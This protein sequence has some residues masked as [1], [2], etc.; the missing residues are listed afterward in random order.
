MSFKEE[1]K[2]LAIALTTITIGLI[3]NYALSFT[4]GHASLSAFIL[5]SYPLQVGGAAM[6]SAALYRLLSNV[7]QK[8]D[9]KS[10][11]YLTYSMS[12]VTF[13]IAIM[14]TN[15]AGSSGM[16]DAAVYAVVLTTSFM[17][18]AGLMLGVFDNEK[19][20]EENKEVK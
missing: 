5:I 7:M 15:I 12:A 6:L 11:R 10:F 4:Q 3:A 8:P 2:S 14:F 13:H 20:Q 17:Y 19:N 16:F 1:E 9:F 18:L